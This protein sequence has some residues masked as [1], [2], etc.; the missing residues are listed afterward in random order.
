[1]KKDMFIQVGK[2]QILKNGF[3][4]SDKDFNNLENTVLTEELYDQMSH[5]FKCVNDDCYFLIFE[6]FALS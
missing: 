3:L 1:M 4:L 5:L 6:T 2:Y